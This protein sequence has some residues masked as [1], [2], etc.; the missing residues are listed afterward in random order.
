M[1]PGKWRLELLNRY[2]KRHP[3]S[4]YKL[5]GSY[6]EAWNVGA[7]AIQFCRY[8]DFRWFITQVDSSGKII[9]YYPANT[10]PGAVRY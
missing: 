7:Y 4:A 3:L 5:F 1:K 8:P 9:R 2:G 6:R 10:P